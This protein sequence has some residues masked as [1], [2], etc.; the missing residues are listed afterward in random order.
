M[1][2][3][4]LFMTTFILVVLMTAVIFFAWR[5]NPLIGGLRE[6]FFA[7]LSALLNI[8]LFLTQPDLP[9][10]LTP[11]L[12]QALLLS[13]GIFAVIG[14]YHYLERDD[15]P[16]KLLLGSAAV[17]MVLTMSFLVMVDNPVLAFGMGSIMTG[18]YFLAASRLAWSPQVHRFPARSLFSLAVAFHGAFMC[19]RIILLMKEVPGLVF[20]QSGWDGAQ[21]ILIEQLVMTPVFGL[22]LLMLANEKNANELRQLAEIDSLT[23]LY[24]RGAF[25]KSLEQ[26]LSFVRRGHLRLCVLVLDVDH[27]KSINDNH[28]HDVGDEVLRSVTKTILSCLRKED[29]M[30]R[31]GG[32]EFAIFMINTDLSDAL[33]VAERI[34]AKVNASPMVVRGHSVNCSISIGATAYASGDPLDRLIRRAD[35]AMYFAKANGRNRVEYAV[36]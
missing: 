16:Y 30:G 36:N 18:I 10:V 32:E 35:Q 12:L 15:I 29:V 4:T 11:L 19:L 24:N 1:H 27:F 3:P 31:L 6:W 9:S 13:T 28:G 5:L 26:A 33:V 8:A 21:W 23:N 22:G 25:L 14:I 7:F 34:R 20:T 17:T 2:S